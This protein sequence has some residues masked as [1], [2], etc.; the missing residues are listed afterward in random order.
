LRPT[1]V[2][3]LTADKTLKT[4]FDMGPLR[5]AFER[6]GA[7]AE[8]LAWDAPHAA[9]REFDLC[10][11]RSTWEYYLAPRAFLDWLTDTA[12]SSRLLNPL[13]IVRWNIDKHYLAELEARGVR[14]VPTEF[15]K[16]GAPVALEERCRRRRWHDVVIK[17]AISAGSFLTRRFAADD[18]EAERYVAEH[19]R[20]RD[21][22]VQPFLCSVDTRGERSLIWIDGRV[23]HTVRKHPR[24]A[25]HEES[26]V[27]DGPPTTDE[28]AITAA[29]LAGLERDILYARVDL[30]CDDEGRACLSELELIEPSLFFD[31]ADGVADWF[32]AG[33]LRRLERS[34]T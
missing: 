25:G 24:F 19:A 10:I 17:P 31:F 6:A 22:L 2:A 8:P 7:V 23:T 18:A 11:L 33:A 15:I 13:P 21:M 26:V 12:A 30:M 27:P 28:L 32:V 20:R 5:A 9:P 4:D 1:R 14:V 29:A 3:L 34:V 16:G